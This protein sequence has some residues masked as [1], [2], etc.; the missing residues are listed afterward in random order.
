VQKWKP[1]RVFVKNGEE[2]EARGLLALRDPA[3]LSPL[4]AVH[5]KP[6]PVRPSEARLHALNGGTW[7]LQR[8]PAVRGKKTTQSATLVN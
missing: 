4:P 3:A 6:V 7:S 1:E 2:P 8:S 5:E